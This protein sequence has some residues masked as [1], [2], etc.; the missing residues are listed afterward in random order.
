MALLLE[1]RGISKRFGG[2]QALDQ[3]DFSL[4]RGEVVGL[5]GENGAGKSTLIKILA[6]VHRMDQ[7]AIFIDGKPVTLQTPQDAQR[8]GI[9]VIYQ[10]LNLTPNQ[11]VAENVF[12]HHPQRMNGIL[13]KIGIIDHR[14]R[15][16]ETAALLAQ[17]GITGLDIRRK[18]GELSVAF[19]QLTEIA[20][21]LALEARLIVMDE[22]TSALPDEEVEHLFEI[23]RRLRERGL[24][25][26]FV[27]HRLN[28]VRAIC[29]RIVVLRDG[30]N[31]GALPVNEASDDRIIAMMVGRSIN[32][33]YPKRPATLGD[34]VL[35]VQG[36]TRRGIIEDISFHLRA[37]EVVGLA[38][39]VGSGRTE[40]A[41]AIFGAD[42]IDKGTIRLNGTPVRIR[43]PQ[44][45][46][47]L[48][49]GY[50][51]EDRKVQG[52]VPGMTVRDNITLAVLRQLA[53]A[54]HVVD[55]SVLE[56]VARRYVHELHLRPP[57]TDLPV[58]SL[59]GGNQQKVVLAKWLAV[60]LKVLL[61]DEPTR[62]IDVGA[63]AEIHGLIDELAHRGMA[64]LLISSE[65]PEVL[66]MSD[67]ILVMSEGRLVGEL[68][69][70]EATQERILA[71]ASGRK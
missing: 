10:E 38:G 33:L 18:V 36:L 57:R 70:E 34:V 37:G 39:L 32:N 59:S 60:D 3:V 9:A 5:L 55:R 67:R 16:R 11:T 25:V 44:D 8:L 20:K 64:I 12:L 19:Q 13:G 29:D 68:S 14:R 15:E 31:A 63:K 27:S 62:G 48:G 17:L 46:R 66:A 53:R 45:A 1:M 22:P 54:G 47:N 42:R 24:G 51:P 30:K 56:G 26:V 40:V 7:G 28:E 52:L 50:V 4:D 35:E 49:I 23:I 41:R 58:G 69:R 43:S 71:L 2:T 21:A 61:L 6:G 65:L